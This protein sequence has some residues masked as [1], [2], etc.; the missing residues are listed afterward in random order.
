[1]DYDGFELI[2]IVETVTKTYRP[3]ALKPPTKPR[4][5]GFKVTHKWRF[6]VLVEV[7]ISDALATDHV[8]KRMVDLVVNG[9]AQS[10][11]D[12][13]SQPAVFTCSEGDQLDAG[14]ADTNSAGTTASDR[15]TG[16]ATLPVV[17]P[18]KPSVTRFVFSTG[19]GA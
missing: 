7:Q 17:A 10:P 16:V 18:T 14:V 13:I 3:I 6:L 12:A 8:T 11:I 2:S 4:V 15:Y 1:M 19:G 9:V 5:L